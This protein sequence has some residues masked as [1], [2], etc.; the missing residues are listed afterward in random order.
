MK[1]NDFLYL[2]ALFIFAAFIW[3]KDLA[4]LT[5]AEDVLPILIAFPL[6][7]WLL[8]PVNF[9]DKESKTSTFFFMTF[10][11]F[12]LIGIAISSCFLLSLCWTAL[13]WHWLSNRISGDK[14]PKLKKLLVLPFLGFPWIMLDLN[15]IGWWFRLSGAHV[16]AQFFNLIGLDVIQE[17]TFLLINKL[18]ISV[19][20]A[21]AG[22]NTL[23][24]MLIAGSALNFMI[25]G[26]STRYWANLI[27]LPIISWV[28]NTARIIAISSVAL[29][30]SP[31]FALGAFHSIGGV[32]IVLT[33][34][35]LCWL[36]FAAQE[37]KSDKTHLPK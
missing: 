14:L 23:Q 27:V 20:E 35:L 26:N 8:S 4:W 24:T 5:S 37:V 30:I 11:I 3:L 15:Q 6:F 2:F 33:M 28:A 10:G 13:L 31:Q 7:I 16:A 22:L 18:P 29:A 25:L 9:V 34:F 17:G 1:K 21:C 36:I 32:F 12:F 19:E